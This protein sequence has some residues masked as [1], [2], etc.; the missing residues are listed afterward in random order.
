[1]ARAIR[2]VNGPHHCFCCVVKIVLYRS[3]CGRHVVQ[4]LGCV[5][6]E[7]FKSAQFAT[8]LK[9]F[10]P[11]ATAC[12]GRIR[13]CVTL[14][15]A[16]RMKEICYLHGNSTSSTN[17]ADRRSE[18]LRAVIL[19]AVVGQA[20]MSTTFACETLAILVKTQHSFPKQ[21][22]HKGTT[23]FILVLVLAVNHI[24]VLGSC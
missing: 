8:D 21:V 22:H 14:C 13:T 6:T 16:I 19:V 24:P 7:E 5:F 2:G 23:I 9:C 11:K 4:V 1:M 17:P 18:V 20:Y 3:L 10:L 12:Y 15:T